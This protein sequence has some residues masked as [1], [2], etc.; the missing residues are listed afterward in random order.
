MIRCVGHLRS[1]ERPELHACFGS[2][3]VARRWPNGVSSNVCDAQRISSC[4]TTVLTKLLAQDRTRL[5]GD[6]APSSCF[7]SQTRCA[8]H[9]C[10]CKSP[11]GAGV[12]R[13]S[14]IGNGCLHALATFVVPKHSVAYKLVPRDKHAL[15]SS[16]TQPRASQVVRHNV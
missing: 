3:A 4:L 10:A 2:L 7:G 13:R 1:I 14:R 8:Q 9:P 12:W 15:C 5:S 16:S 11:K 6:F